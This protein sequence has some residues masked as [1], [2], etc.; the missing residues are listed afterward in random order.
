MGTPA[1]GREVA[2]G[3]CKSIAELQTTPA[4]SWWKT[5]KVLL[6]KKL[7]KQVRVEQSLFRNRQ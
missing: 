4:M 2:A 1:A 7:G 3:R 5:G 6:A